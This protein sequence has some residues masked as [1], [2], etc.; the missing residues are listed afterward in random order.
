MGQGTVGREEIALLQPLLQPF[1]ATVV[2]RDGGASTEPRG[3]AS[4]SGPPTASGSATSTSAVTIVADGY[5]ST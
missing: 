1:A 3:A 5:A 4:T 2:P